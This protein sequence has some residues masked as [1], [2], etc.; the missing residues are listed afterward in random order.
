MGVSC[1]CVALRALLCL[2][3]LGPVAYTTGSSCSALRA[4]V[5]QVPATH[6][7]G[8]VY[9]SVIASLN[10]PEGFTSLPKPHKSPA[11]A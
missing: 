11:R 9:Q 10:S 6:T 7:S 2:A 4:P 1:I 5:V 8:P 3:N